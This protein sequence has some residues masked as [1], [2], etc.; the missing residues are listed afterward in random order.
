MSESLSFQLAHNL[1]FLAAQALLDDWLSDKLREE[2][3]ME[4]DDELKDH[5][6][7]TQPT[8]AASAQPTCIN[9]KKFDGIF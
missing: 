8:A 6:E 3:Y 9:Y 4:D 5:V 7:N 2:L 1:L